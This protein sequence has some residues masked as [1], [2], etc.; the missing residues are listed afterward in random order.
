MKFSNQFRPTHL[1][2]SIC[3]CS[4]FFFSSASSPLAD[5][6]ES[7]DNC[8][9]CKLCRFVTHDKQHCR[10]DDTTLV[11]VLVFVFLSRQI[12]RQ[13]APR[14]SWLLSE[15]HNNPDLLVKSCKIFLQSDTLV[16]ICQIGARRIGCETGHGRGDLRRAH[17]WCFID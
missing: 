14:Q 5:C 10:V 15:A 3:L 17:L 11:L 8:P 9:A 6:I 16:E 1:F 4:S 7:S 12:T 2:D 13:I